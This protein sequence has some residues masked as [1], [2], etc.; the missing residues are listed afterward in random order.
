MPAKKYPKSEAVRASEHSSEPAFYTWGKSI[1]EIKGETS[2]ALELYGSLE[3][4]NAHRFQDFSNLAPGISGRPGMTRADYDWFRPDE[5]TPTEPKAIIARSDKA[6]K[7][8]GLIRNII[9]LMGDFACQGVVISHPN[10]RIQ[11]FYRNWWK[12]VHG[13]E[14]SER[15]LNLFYRIGNVIVRRK[16]ARLPAKTKQKL[17]K[18]VGADTDMDIVELK[19]D[20]NIIPW[21]YI[22][23][24]PGTL[25]VVGGP[26][27]NFVG[28][29]LYAMKLPLS[30]SR[31]IQNLQGSDK[32]AAQKLIS[33]IPRD[34]LNAA[35]SNRPVMLDNDKIISYYYKRD[36]WEVWASPMIGGILDNIDTLVKLRLADV[37]ALDGAISNIRLW[38]LGSLDHKIAPSAAAV[39]R[40]SDALENNT[41]V[42]TMD[43]IWGPDIELVES[44]TQVHQFLGEDKYKPTLNAIYAG[45]GIPPTLTGTFGAAGTTNNFISLKTLMQRLQYGRDQLMDFWSHEIRMVQEAMG[46]RQ[47]A[48]LEFTHMNLLDEVAEKALLVQLV[49]RNIISDETIQRIFGKDPEMEN[50]RLKRERR[51]READRRVPKAGPWYTEPEFD[52]ALKK[53]ALQQGIVTPSQ[54]GLE[55]EEGNPDET[56]AMDKQADMQLKIAQ[57]RKPPGQPQQGRPKNS[58]DKNGRK[59]KEFKPKQKASKIMELWALAALEDLDSRLNE[60]I[61]ELYSKK[62]MRSLSSEEAIKAEKIKFGVLLSLEPYTKITD[63]K[64]AQALSKTINSTIYNTY[65]SL[66][67]ETSS[68][69]S[70]PLTKEEC[71]SIQ[72]FIFSLGE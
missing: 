57:E 32:E 37:A 5:A 27:S 47:P 60:G 10:P 68:E 66:V 22:F 58:K 15:F 43:L 65:I 6:Y 62:N 11:K 21:Q 30:L 56:P 46:F 31:A 52:N 54:V 19:F 4:A 23:L 25:E 16:T 39:L 14:R 51:E 24:H 36:D 12:R 53:I 67:N 63:E 40:L 33:K 38:K 50:I 18:T 17:F 2:K 69:L 29:R 7:R 45:L 72:A 9:D 26:L 42:G 44:K 55:L 71:R 8:V 1:D 28:Q 3:R 61:L 64:V 49:D 41:G 20:K 34:I 59:Q 48:T 70:R 35:K 13:K